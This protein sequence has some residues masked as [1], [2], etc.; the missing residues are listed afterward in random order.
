MKYSDTKREYTRKRSVEQHE[1][2][3]SLLDA[4]RED[5]AEA[6]MELS[7]ADNSG[8]EQSYT[9]HK[10]DYEYDEYTASSRPSQNRDD[11]RSLGGSTAKTKNSKS[12]TST[13][14]SSIRM[15]LTPRSMTPP[16][17]RNAGPRKS[18][19][20]GGDYWKAQKDG[21]G[22]SS[23]GEGSIKSAS[24]GLYV[25]S[26]EQV[27][28]EAIDINDFNDLKR[29]V[30]NLTQERD[31]LLK[32][33]DTWLMRVKKDNVGLAAMLK[34][35]KTLKG[36]LVKAVDEVT[37]EKM[38]LRSM[39][40]DYMSVSLEEYLLGDD[41]AVSES[42]RKFFPPSKKD[43]AA[44][45]C[46]QLMNLSAACR[47]NQVKVGEY[48]KNLVTEAEG[49]FVK[50]DQKT[51]DEKLDA[52]K[53]IASAEPGNYLSAQAAAASIT[54]A[55]VGA[56]QDRAAEVLAHRASH[57]S[58]IDSNGI[59]G[60]LGRKDEEIQALITQ[61][62][63]LKAN[64]NQWRKKYQ[65]L[66]EKATAKAAAGSGAPPSGVGGANSK[67]NHLFA[68]ENKQQ[69]ARNARKSTGMG[70]VHGG[71]GET[72][73]QSGR[74]SVT[75]AILMDM[76]KVEAEELKMTHKFDALPFDV[77]KQANDALTQY[78][79][80]VVNAH[81]LSVGMRPVVIKE[82]INE[83]ATQMHGILGLALGA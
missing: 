58:H 28:R 64:V 33:K 37:T 57:L 83:V 47:E 23:G 27:A 25:K 74:R 5:L 36:E 66:L 68:D 77:R 81:P 60:R 31:I 41:C 59:D 20:K 45:F 21:G 43:A 48:V 56:M 65:V 50:G 75:S 29:Q 24:S 2:N 39:K 3:M 11:D 61:T 51:T 62:E 72:H 12:S 15:S 67:S 1:Q 38:A 18:V 71:Y 42:R 26:D 79:T 46:E 7:S 63:N 76:P 30:A 4:M 35:V 40:M 44:A 9:E 73:S 32:E 19:L 49:A 6:D 53:N 54:E 13:G 52:L 22:S 55:M 80:T 16:L 78:V 8:N 69:G 34:H 14:R 10:G 17:K 82:T 70:Q